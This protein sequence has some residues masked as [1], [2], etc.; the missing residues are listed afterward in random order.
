MAVPELTPAEL[1]QAVEDGRDVHILDIRTPQQLGSGQVDIVADERFHNIPVAEFDLDGD[2]STIDLAPAPE[3]AVVCTR[4]NDSAKVAEFLSRHGFKAHSMAGGMYAWMAMEL[5]RDLAP[6]PHLDKLLQFDRVGKGALG[7][8]LVS[9]GEGFIVDPP[10]HIAEFVRAVEGAGVTVVGIGDT[11]A[12][13]DYISGGPALARVF[14]APYYLHEKDSFYPYDGT[15]GK[16]AYENAEDGRVI[17]VG[18]AAITC[19]HTPGH[20]E[21]SVTYRIGDDLAF[22]GDFLFIKTVGRPDLGEQTV[23]WT[24]VLFDSLDR[25]RAEWPNSLRVCPAHYSDEAER[26]ADGTFV[27][28][29]GELRTSN[30]QLAMTNREVFRDWV[31]GRAGAFPDA[32]RQIKGINVGLIEADEDEMNALEAGRNQCAL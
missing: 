8:L 14:G 6:G 17:T 11:H 16:V 18:R 1:V 27:R 12:H 21:G 3:Y 4:G 13:A 22:T 10:R 31:H 32:Y 5:V 2:A 30:E 20:T 24:D 23:A 26:N 25:A 15:P 29:L 9:D 19:V 28:T 7:Y